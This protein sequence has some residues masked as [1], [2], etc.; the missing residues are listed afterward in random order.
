M[1]AK[2]QREQNVRRVPLFLLAAILLAFATFYMTLSG[3]WL[4]IALAI[5]I[6][7]SYILPW[8]IET[9]SMSWLARFV[10]FFIAVMASF[11]LVDVV[12]DSYIDPRW[13]MLFGYICAAE[14]TLQYW[15]RIP[16]YGILLSFPCLIFMIASTTFDAKTIVFAAPAF[17]FF[18]VMALPSYRPRVTR[19]WSVVLWRFGIAGALLAAGFG[20]NAL[21]LHFSDELNSFGLRMMYSRYQRTGLSIDPSLGRTFNLRGSAQRIMK[22]EG[23]RGEMH[24]R[25]AAFENYN[26]GRWL[27]SMFSRPMEI[28]PTRIASTD[29]TAR[30][31]HVTELARMPRVLFTTIDT[32]EVLL[33]YQTRWSPG[34]GGPIV[35]EER[36]RVEYDIIIA[37]QQ[38]ETLWPEPNALQRTALLNVPPEI[39]PKVRELAQRIVGQEA[40]PQRKIAQV[41]NYLTSEHNYSLTTDPGP[42]DP[43]SNFLLEK[44]DAHCEFFAAAATMLLRCVDVPTRYVVGY[45]AHEP[46]G[47][48]AL[49]VRQ[50]D[51]HAW[52]ESW[53]DGEG[54]VTVEATPG[55]GLPDQSDESRP[56]WIQKA[57]EKVQD[58][59]SA[60]L[61][62]LDRLTQQQVILL[63]IAIVVPYFLI[64]IWVARRRERRKASTKARAYQLYD[65]QFAELATRF[66]TWMAQRG[67]PCPPT[68]PWHEH[69]AES[70]LP[71]AA[72]EFVT[73]Y[74]AMRFSMERDEVQ[75]RALAELL[76]Q[77]VLETPSEAAQDVT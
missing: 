20:G 3:S 5:V 17:I 54:W 59:F 32:G 11:L 14:I 49:V 62:F 2:E 69:L 53:I 45:Y 72:M 1:A 29:E 44:K 9:E 40:T 31:V 65:Q 16:G 35:H 77:L 26:F 6:V 43:I 13:P 39:D 21:L 71:E 48:N 60:L 52:A 28:L 19:G 63:V 38:S 56:S 76:D 70:S 36:G 33:Q 10:L 46:W 66:E 25:A 34:F 8:R 51:A 73:R 55:G 67:H 4:L 30:L 47:D 23:Q 22:V 12:E 42:G 68:A 37:A 58:V 57:I 64:Q 41:V 61:A 27:P 7:I 75:L 50:R 18:I 24:L 74:N 15:R